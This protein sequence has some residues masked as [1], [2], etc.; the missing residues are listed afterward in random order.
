VVREGDPGDAF[1][2]LFEGE[3]RVFVD[4]FGVEKDVGRLTSGT[5]FGEI[6][7]LTDQPRT[8][9]ISA[10]K[11]S[12]LVRFPRDAVRALLEDYPRLKELVSAVGVKRSEDTLKKILEE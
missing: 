8:A 12:R 10:A 5:F 11:P 1:Y 3:L 2:L 7:T 6:A 9:S 4:D